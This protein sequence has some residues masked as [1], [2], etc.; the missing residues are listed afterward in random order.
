MFYNHGGIKYS[1]VNIL[2]FLR[3]Y[4][5]LH[6]RYGQSSAEDLGCNQNEDINAQITCLQE[7]PL[8]N[9][10]NSNIVVGFR[11][12]QAVVDGSFSDEPFLPDHPKILM[13]SGMYNM[14]VNIL[15]GN[16][17]LNN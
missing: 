9:I 1:L 2:L 8:E 6:L 15:L 11:G 5:Y 14:D 17:R 7:L 13:S 12:A 4:Q 3:L 10:V 16:N